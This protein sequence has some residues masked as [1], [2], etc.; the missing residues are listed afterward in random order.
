VWL[1]SHRI[2][3]VGGRARFGQ[4]TNRDDIFV[5]DGTAAQTHRSYAASNP[6][7][8]TDGS[9]QYE[10]AP[11]CDPNCFGAGVS[12]FP[13]SPGPQQPA[14]YTFAYNLTIQHEFLKDSRLEVSY[15]GSRSKLDEQ[16]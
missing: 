4:F 13:A 8:A 2:G 15:V 1:G 14:P 5:T 12:A 10:P 3:E 11:A 6:L 7:T 16:V 9:R